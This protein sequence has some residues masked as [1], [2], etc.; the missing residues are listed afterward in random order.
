MKI[1]KNDVVRSS[2]VLGRPA[3]PLIRRWL[4]K[5]RRTR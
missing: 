4:K 1:P 3:K 5:V 2:S